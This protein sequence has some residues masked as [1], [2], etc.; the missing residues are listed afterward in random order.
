[1]RPHV[2]RRPPSRPPRAG[3]SLIEMMITLVLLAVVGAVIATVMIGS[4][5][6]KAVTE[7]RVEAQQSARFIAGILGNDIRS[8]GYQIDETTSPAQTAFAYVDS[9]EIILNANLVPFPDTMVSAIA[10]HALDPAGAPIPP[11]LA[12]SPYR[13]TVK[14]TTGAES[15]RYTLDLDDDGDIDAGDQSHSL[16][17]EAQR[18]ANPNDYVL[19]R[20]IYG[21]GSGGVLLNNGGALEKVGL[22]RGPGPDV[23]PLFTVYLGANPTP[24]DWSDGAIPA[25]RLDEV[26]RIELKVTTESRRAGPGGDYTRTTLT[27][28]INSIRNVPAAGSTIYAVE[29]W[30]FDD[31]DQST[32]RDT[33]EPGIP[34]AIIRL[35][36]VSVGTSNSAGYYRVSGPPAVYPLVQEVPEGFGAF[37]PD[38]VTIDFIASPGD[39]MHSFADT[40]RSGAWLVDSCFIDVDSDG[41]RSA[42]DEP[43]G[44]VGM[45]VAGLTRTSDSNGFMKVFLSPGSYAVSYTA[46]E[47]TIVVSANPAS[48][49]I[50][51]GV[52]VTLYTLLVRGGTGTVTGTV[53]RDLDKDGVRDGGETGIANA[54]V[55]VTKNSGAATLAFAMTDSVGGYSIVAPINMPAATTPYEVTV[56]PPSGWYPT[57]PTQISP[58]WL[59]LGQTLSGNDFGMSNFTQITLNAD[60]VLSLSS[61]DLLEKD[62]GGS[63]SQFLTK[64]AFDKDLVL[65]SEYVS[66]PNVSVWFNNWD[67]PTISTTFAADANYA[68]NAQSSA[69]SVAVGP[70]DGNTPVMR[71]DVVT[72][73]AR[74]PSGNIAVWLNQNASGNEGFLVTTPVL[75]QTQNTGDANV[76]V[77]QDFGGSLAIDFMVGTTG[78]T[79]QGTLETWINNG[80]GAFI[81]DEIY[82]PNGNLPSGSLGEV[83][84]LAFGEV[85][86]DTNKDLIVGTKIAPGFGRVHVLGLNTRNANDRY[87]HTR[88]F[89]VVGEVTSMLAMNVDG[90]G[91]LDIVVGTRISPS[92]GNI[93]YWKGQ[94]SGNF[95]IASVFVTEGPVLS[96]A[97]G[98]FGGS[99]R[100]DIAYGFRTD[101]SAYTG[102][103]RILFLD[104]GTLPP[105]DVDPAGG[106]HDWMAPALAVNNFNFRLNPATAGTVLSDLAVATKT[107]VSTGALLVFIR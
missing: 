2:R 107:G 99:S 61:G 33:G 9:V 106:T 51:A 82:P 96:L 74:K 56:I 12:A 8:A 90:D 44:G 73:L 83:K 48:V 1:M 67:P 27:S 65:G 29:G 13:P 47:S 7:A 55:G 23:P 37:A 28:E 17:V 39:Y 14:Y 42:G 43:A 52:D 76:V 60:R 62:W 36:T 92:A 78:A 97:K 24:W 41:V 77:L 18:T 32:T 49:S 81:R 25:D 79:N 63:A 103:S 104:L 31:L 35:G 38:S 10:P 101:E 94:G 45:S 105:D 15:I 30:V 59:S 70:L 26:S 66:N 98:D 102:G 85:T 88:S 68:R 91:L 93:Q 57:T 3:F 72:G 46:P 16:A 100:E 58:L 80:S 86:G 95:A 54:W 84:A 53:Y 22:V 6:S 5:R 21:G 19:A 71:E 69:L 64:A 50:T 40:A 20:A 89:D 4:Q 34:D 11:R 75:Y 87:R